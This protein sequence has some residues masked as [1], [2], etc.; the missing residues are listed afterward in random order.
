MPACLP[1]LFV[2][3][4]RFLPCY[5]SVRFSGTVL[6]VAAISVCRFVFLLS[7]LSAFCSKFFLQFFLLSSFRY[8]S[9]FGF[10]QLLTLFLVLTA[11]SLCFGVASFNR[12][13]SDSLPILRFQIN[14]QLYLIYCINSPVVWQRNNFRTVSRTFQA[15]AASLLFA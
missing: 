3:G 7:S 2:A 8:V 15:L 1:F 12:C 5:R 6:V 13:T 10:R 9:W 14:G 4:F 11:Q